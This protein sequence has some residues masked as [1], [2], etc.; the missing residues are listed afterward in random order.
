MFKEL[1]ILYLSCNEISDISILNEVNFKK[2][3]QLD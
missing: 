3:K 1:Q 2:L